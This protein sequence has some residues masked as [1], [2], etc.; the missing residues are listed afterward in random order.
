MKFFQIFLTWSTP[1]L[2]RPLELSVIIPTLN[3]ER[4][5]GYVLSR[6]PWRVWRWGEILVIDSS[7]DRTP[8]IARKFGARVIKVPKRGKG[9]AM[10]IGAQEAQ[11][12]V[13][14][15]MD[16]DGT[17]PP[18]YIPVMA[19]ATKNYDVVIC[20]RNPSHQHG[21]YRYRLA[22]YVYMPMLCKLFH[23]I[24]F[25]V[26]GDPLAG[27]RAMRKKIW[28]RLRIKSNDFFIET[29]INIKI[30]I[31]GLSVLEIPIPTLPR[32]DSI[33]RSKFLRSINQ[34]MRILRTLLYLKNSKILP[35]MSRAKFTFLSEEIHLDKFDV[36]E[37]IIDAG[38]ILLE[39]LRMMIPRIGAP[40]A[41]GIVNRHYGDIII[42]QINLQGLNQKLRVY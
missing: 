25:N 28:N 4:N 31:L 5:I 38:E 24:G 35:R 23:E 33:I 12:D 29:E 13:L 42:N 39:K 9:Y 14:V 6:I 37:R 19:K 41:S 21:S 40:A 36:D 18:E 26:R 1:E 15:F 17:D 3:E 10:K 34:Q 7:T 32:G 22:S 11:G 30:L 16:G 2:V 8:I 27:F 20:A